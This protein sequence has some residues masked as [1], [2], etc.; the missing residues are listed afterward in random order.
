MPGHIF[1]RLGLWQEDI[2][3]NLA[4]VEASRTAEARGQNGWMDQF[5]SDDFL[6][7]AYL[8]SGQEAR[9]K[10]IAADAQQVIA[11]HETMAHMGTD[12][13][14]VGMLPYYRVKLPIF[15]A[16]E[17][18]NWRAVQQIEPIKD[19]PADTQLQI[20][21]AHVIAAGHLHQAQQAR[22]DLAASDALMAEV[23]KGARAYQVESIGAQIRRGEM[24]AWVAVTA[25]DTAEAVKQVRTS[26]D[27]QDKV[28]QG[29]VD[30]PAREM[31]GDILLDAGNP[32]EALA[33]YKQV[34]K[35]SPNRFNALFN[36]GK[37]A[38][39]AG[40][41]VEA[42]G[43]YTALLQ[44]TDNGSRSARGEIEHAKAFVTSASSAQSPASAARD[45]L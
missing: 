40:D 9:A 1:A 4:S 2:A 19:A 23:K 27:L 35:L 5:H 10:A 28:G 39:A 3:S 43:Y 11:H 30:I 26:A 45:L 21:W 20:Y 31:L 14:M 13:Y 38:E 24:L 7:Y 17:T 15:I 16:L 8:Q 33:E 29:E 25:G 41:P 37:A 22:S 12:G 42:R 18:R 34:M 44:V 36:A 32:R 6:V